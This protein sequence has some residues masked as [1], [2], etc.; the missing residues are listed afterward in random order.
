MTKKMNGL[1]SEFET[2][3]TEKINGLQSEIA[4]LKNETVTDYERMTKQG[5]KLLLIYYYKYSVKIIFTFST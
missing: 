1:Q 2:K 3:L 4:T 5:T